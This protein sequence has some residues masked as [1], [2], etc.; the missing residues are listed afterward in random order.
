[1]LFVKPFPREPELHLPL[2][3]RARSIDEKWAALA[4][5]HDVYW[6]G[7]DKINPSP[8]PEDEKFDLERWK[9]WVA[10]SLAFSRLLERAG[11]LADTDH[12][13][14]ARWL[15]DAIKEDATPGEAT[16]E[17]P[18]PPAGSED[19]SKQPTA[20][21]T[22]GQ[23]TLQPE[24]QQPPAG[25]EQKTKRPC[26]DRDKLFLQWYESED[27]KTYHSHAEIRN[28]WNTMSKDE[29][30]KICPSNPNNVTRSTAI[31]A[32][33]AAKRDRAEEEAT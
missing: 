11:G 20:V 30:T 31:A 1:V 5:I 6:M 33:K 23:G 13:V 14:I 18:A 3:H 2:S 26:R 12:P 10:D 32:I 27:T 25:G 24:S 15:K 29:R 17:P 21:D 7:G 28:K 19:Q 4:A 22:E 9:R 8:P 16:T